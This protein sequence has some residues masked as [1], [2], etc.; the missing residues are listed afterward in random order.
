MK[1]WTLPIIMVCFLI[2]LQQIV[3]AQ[4]KSISWGIGFLSME[5]N[6]YRGSKQSRFWIYPTPYF[7]Y[8]SNFL[9]AEPSFVRGLIYQHKKF[10]IKLSLMAGL[11]VEQEKNEVRVGMSALDYTFE[12]GPIMIYHLWDSK[13]N[14][15]SLDFNMPIRHVF[16]TNFHYVKALGWFS[17]PYVSLNYNKH[18]LESEFSVGP[19]YSER[20]LHAYY[21]DVN[22]N[23]QSNLR[24]EFHSGGGYSGFQTA[25]VTRV[26]YDHYIILNFLRWD[27]LSSSAFSNSPLV[28]TKQFFVAGLGVF[29][30]FSQN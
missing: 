1:T 7:S 24:G 16:A 29:W 25:L 8:K 23:E 22:R 26:S 30:M 27:N 9:E 13:N 2:S 20:S 5:L 21:Y 19:M 14:S 10:A 12:L 28:Q 15:L 17:V 3:L 6:Q 11:N 4:D 18:N